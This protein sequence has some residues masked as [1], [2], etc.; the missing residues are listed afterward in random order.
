MIEWHDIHNKTATTIAK[1]PSNIAQLTGWLACRLGG[2]DAQFDLQYFQYGLIACWFL[3]YKLKIKTFFLPLSIRWIRSNL[4]N[5]HHKKWMQNLSDWARSRSLSARDDK[6]KKCVSSIRMTC[7]YCVFMFETKT[8]HS[9][10]GALMDL[11]L[12]VIFVLNVWSFRWH[13]W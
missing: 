5:L 8:Y 7:N 9:T 3:Q 2:N 4:E 6:M 10:A 13:H 12:L 11:L 1:R